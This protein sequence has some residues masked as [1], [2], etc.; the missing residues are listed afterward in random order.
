MYDWAYS[1]YYE[2]ERKAREIG[3]T[4]REL[5][6]QNVNWRNLVMKAFF[7]K[8]ITKHEKDEL[9]YFFPEGSNPRF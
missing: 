5:Y 1:L 6:G 8:V 2:R 4:I 3:Q 9:F 7:D